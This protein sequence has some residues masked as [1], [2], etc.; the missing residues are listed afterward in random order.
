[1]ANKAEEVWEAMNR[2]YTQV[3]SGRH[4]PEGQQVPK[5]ERQ[6]KVEIAQTIQDRSK[7]IEEAEKAASVSADTNETNAVKDE[8]ESG[9]NVADLSAT[10]AD[11]SKESEDMEM[12]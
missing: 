7:A 5:W 4:L 3:I 2:D 1:M 11:S 9:S 6:L 12:S 8:E 10:G